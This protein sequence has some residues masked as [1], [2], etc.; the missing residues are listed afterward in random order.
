MTDI[1]RKEAARAI[2]EKLEDET[3]R[4]NTLR[5]AAE[6]LTRHD[7]MLSRKGVRASGQVKRQ[8]LE[9]MTELQRMIDRHEQD[10]QNIIAVI[11][12]ITETT[13]L[14]NGCRDYLVLRYVEGMSHEEAAEQMGISE[15]HLA[16]KRIR[17]ML[18]FCDAWEARKNKVG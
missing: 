2:L 6:H 12:S 8:R 5:C 17:A 13:R 3:A 9:I 4:I 18:L 1:E 16:R 15:K 11:E 10:R 7:A 14:E